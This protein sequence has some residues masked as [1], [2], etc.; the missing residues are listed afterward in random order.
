MLR[1]A[2]FQLDQDVKLAVEARAMNAD[3]SRLRYQVPAE[4]TGDA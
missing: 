2:G 1:A 3:A 4:P